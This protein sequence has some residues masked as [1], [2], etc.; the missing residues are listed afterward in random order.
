MNRSHLPFEGL[1][2]HITVAVVE[3]SDQAVDNPVT[4]VVVFEKEVGTSIRE[5]GAKVN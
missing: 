4:A 5:H 1:T 2:L 3:Q